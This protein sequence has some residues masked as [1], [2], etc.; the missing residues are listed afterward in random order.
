MSANAKEFVPHVSFVE[1]DWQSMCFQLEA[2]TIQDESPW[3][4]GILQ[5]AGGIGVRR[6]LKETQSANS[7]ASSA[8]SIAS[9][10]VTMSDG[11]LYDWTEKQ[12]YSE[13]V[14][15]LEMCLAHLEKAAVIACQ[16]EQSTRHVASSLDEKATEFLEEYYTL[17]EPQGIRERLTENRLIEDQFCS[18]EVNYLG[19]LLIGDPESFR[20]R[21]AAEPS[22][23]SAQLFDLV[24]SLSSTASSDVCHVLCHSEYE[25][26][27]GSHEESAF[28]WQEFI[29][30]ER[31]LIV[32]RLLRHHVREI[33]CLIHTE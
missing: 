9:P 19:H 29:D 14:R 31:L 12:K 33:E 18:M 24:G 17:L 28:A 13:R 1:V 8:G 7:L 11:E 32:L 23:V 2:S 16:V 6:V 22:E 25:T 20:K 30:D 3:K 21:I 15:H 10:G 27:Y 5:S 4:S 26:A